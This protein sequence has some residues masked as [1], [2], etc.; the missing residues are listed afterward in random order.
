MNPIGMFITGPPNGSVLYVA[1]CRLSATS[2]VACN[3]RGRSA[4]AR[5][6]AWPVG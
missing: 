1:R 6:G 4:A 5:P 2:V 3:A